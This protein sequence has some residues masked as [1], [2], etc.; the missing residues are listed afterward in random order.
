MLAKRI[1]MLLTV[2]SVKQSS[3]CDLWKQNEKVSLLLSTSQLRESSM[4]IFDIFNF[5]KQKTSANTARERLRIIVESSANDR[6]MP[7][8]KELQAEI[9]NV[10]AKYYEIPQ[11]DVNI[12][13]D[14]QNGK[15]VLELS[16]NI[17]EDAKSASII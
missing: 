3:Q 14:Q 5:N 8:I 6:K 7:K 15:T 9:F 13:I 2:F 4:S 10:I 16:V 17:A 1:W 11:D 12:Q